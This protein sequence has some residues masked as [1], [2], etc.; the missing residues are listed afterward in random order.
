MPPNSERVDPRVERTHAVVLEA[1]RDLL[2]EVGLAR[3]SIEAIAERSGVARS[4]IY[5][6]W[7]ST[8]ALVMAA[9]EQAKAEAESAVVPTGDDEAD[10]RAALAGLGHA[11]RSP[12]ANLLADIAAAA[13]RDAELAEL[14]QQYLARRR[15]TA[16]RLIG[17]LQAAGRI[18]EDLTASAVTDLV[19]GPIF[20]R[21][22]Q[23]RR[24]MSDDEIDE[25]ATLMFQV[26][27]PQR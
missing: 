6:H 20:Y 26:L 23:S 8:A 24:P 18:R 17:R 10:L 16:E 2:N 21:C 11:L 22:F 13:S 27:A 9:L 25:L 7:P 3:T 15:A 19:S 14:H 5:R 4:T 12:M 1:T